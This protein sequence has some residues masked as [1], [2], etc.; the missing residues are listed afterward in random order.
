MCAGSFGL[1]IMCSNENFNHTLLKPVL[2]LFIFIHWFLCFQKETHNNYKIERTDW[3]I[4]MYCLIN[5][6]SDVLRMLDSSCSIDFVRGGSNQL[7]GN[8]PLLHI[9][10]HVQNIRESK[11]SWKQILNLTKCTEKNTHDTP[12]DLQNSNLGG[13]PVTYFRSTRFTYASIKF[14][15]WCLC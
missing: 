3:W 12:N 15:R 2:C 5:H 1:V 13:S 4:W 8:I 6:A 14:V 7:G 11:I 9:R 10:H